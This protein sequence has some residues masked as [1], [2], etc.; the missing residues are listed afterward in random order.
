MDQLINFISSFAQSVD[1]GEQY[2]FGKYKTIGDFISVLIL[3][4]LILGGL[5]ILY[6]FLLASYKMLTAGGN[7]DEMGK[8]RAM[9]THGIIGFL[10][11]LVAFLVLMFI[12]EIFKLE[13]FKIIK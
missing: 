5:S 11:L 13:G 9:I 8:A 2:G 12:P 10:L 1:L 6:Y 3:P 4:G 7:K